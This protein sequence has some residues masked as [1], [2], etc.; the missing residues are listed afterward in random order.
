MGV[1]Q[2]G[3]AGCQK[4]CSPDTKVSIASRA[5]FLPRVRNSRTSSQQT[6][7]H[8][9]TPAPPPSIALSRPLCPS[10]DAFSKMLA[11]SSIS[12]GTQRALKPQ[13]CAQ[14]AQRR[15]LAAPA[16]GSFQ[17]QTG[18][19]SGLK[20]ASRDMAGP[21][22]TLAL[23][24]KAGTRYQA[25]PG[26]TEGLEKFAFM[27]RRM[28]RE[29][30]KAASELHYELDI[31]QAN[32]RVPRGDPLCELFVSLSSLVQS[33]HPTI[34]GRTSSLAQSSFAT[35]FHTTWSSL[36][37]LLPRLDSHVCYYI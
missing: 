26:L 36:L 34:L 21:T 1:L 2:K 18:D 19:A 10:Q 13:C 22:T 25:F 9:Q 17:Y 31:N 28:S 7:F 8:H 37:R 32:H 33:C 35:T 3:Y 27:V 14:L 4:L 6:A 23:V 15:G 24:A 12:R 5:D 20:F 30:R 16:S 11:R 29:A